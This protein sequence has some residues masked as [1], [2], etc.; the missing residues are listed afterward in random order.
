MIEPRQALRAIG[1]LP[2]GEIDLADAALQLARARSSGVEA[3]RA[4]SHLSDLAREAAAIGQALGERPLEVQL[5]ALA[6][7]IHVRHGYAGD[8]ETYD[9]VAN[10][11]LVRVIERRCGLPVALGIV[12][13]HCIRA[14]GWHGRGIDFPRHFLIQFDG[15]WPAA[16]R[17]GASQPPQLLVDVFSG[18][19]AI[20]ADQLLSMVRRRSTDEARLDAE[21]L[22]PM[23]NRE[24]LLRLQRN[25]AERLRTLGEWEGTLSVLETMADI[26]P[27]DALI[28]RDQAALHQRLGRLAAAMACL[29]RFVALAPSGAA[30]DQARDG[31]DAIR[32]RLT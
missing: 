22:R 23:G 18:G 11:D 1:R 31:I 2:D 15:P 25:I 9:D 19:Q 6:G 29:E 5:G 17:R 27:D 21:L 24:V 13:L 3:E 4:A 12:W 26:A 8:A 10:A 16:A 7:L 14:A 28:W 20:G 32:R 30:A